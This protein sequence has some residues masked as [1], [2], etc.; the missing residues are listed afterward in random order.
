MSTVDKVA[1]GQLSAYKAETATQIVDRVNVKFPPVP[2]VGAKGDN[3]S[4]DTT[5][6]QA[7]ADYCKTNSKILYF[8]NGAFLFT[9]LNLRGSRLISDSVQNPTFQFIEAL[10]VECSEGTILKHIGTGVGIE[11]GGT[12]EIEEVGTNFSRGGYLKKLQLQGNINSTK[13][14][15]IVKNVEG[16]VDVRVDY[17]QIGIETKEFNAGQINL[18]LMWQQNTGWFISGGTNGI[19]VG[20]CHIRRCQGNPITTASA[21]QSDSSYALHFNTLILEGNLLPCIIGRCQSLI[22]DGHYSEANV[23]GDFIIGGVGFNVD[24]FRI[25]S[26]LNL[27]TNDGTPVFTFVGVRN[28]IVDIGYLANGDVG[29]NVINTD[30]TSR[31]EIYTPSFSFFT[32][33]SVVYDS[34]GLA[35]LIDKTGGWTYSKIFNGTVFVKSSTTIDYHYY[36]KMFTGTATTGLISTR[37]TGDTTDR[38]NIRADGTI[39]NGLGDATGYMQ[40]FGFVNFGAGLIGYGNRAGVI[41]WIPVK[42]AG[43][44]VTAG[45]GVNQKGWEWFNTT[46]NKKKFWSGTAI[47]TVTSA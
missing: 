36:K 38:V 11:W 2:M 8:P 1:R 39:E 14:L 31:F 40:Q 16:E 18:N 29:C 47:E 33:N 32:G 24:G 43:D 19:E 6:I 46:A 37:V 12:G 23:K 9:T 44:P 45:W 7:I 35:I 28:A 34:D 3:S 10:R 42:I 21:L 27:S 26:Y 41:P 13:V 17:G 22:I 15:R 5:V 20:K 30:N 4:D 25:K